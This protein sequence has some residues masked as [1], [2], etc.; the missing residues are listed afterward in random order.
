MKPDNY[1]QEQKYSNAKRSVEDL[2]AYYWHLAIYVVIN[3]F[4]SGVQVVDGITENKS[5]V[6]TFS[7]FGMYAVWIIWGTGLAFHTLKV[8]GIPFFFRKRMGST[9]IREYMNN[10]G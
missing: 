6:E 10:K 1:L 9:D 4:L 5:F 2:K 3:L 8:F 7:D